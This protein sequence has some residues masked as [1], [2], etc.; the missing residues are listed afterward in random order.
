LINDG[1]AVR[2]AKNFALAKIERK[3]RLPVARTV[4]DRPSQ[5]YFSLMAALTDPQLGEINAPPR[6]PY[7]KASPEGPALNCPAII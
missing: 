1:R 7:E 6:A 4:I 3:Y 5:Q 2:R